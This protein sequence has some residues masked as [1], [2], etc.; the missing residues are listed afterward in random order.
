MKGTPGW[1]SLL[2][3]V[4]RVWGVAVQ[5]PIRACFQGT[6]LYS[7]DASLYST[8]LLDKTWGERDAG[9]REPRAPG[10]GLMPEGPRGPP[11]SLKNHGDQWPAWRDWLTCPLQSRRT[12]VGS[13]S[14]RGGQF[15]YL[16]PTMLWFCKDALVYETNSGLLNFG[17][18]K[19]QGHRGERG[20]SYW[21]RGQAVADKAGVCGRG[22]VKNRAGRRLP[23]SRV[24]R[25]TLWT[26]EAGSGL[27]EAGPLC[28]S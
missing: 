5:G 27:G 21:R 14:R 15:P 12:G 19:L 25:G 9:L 4:P 17:E 13:P 10:K 1:G 16:L 11:S 20:C 6:P 18:Q 2:S 8:R 24:K 22:R 3:C 28:C 7:R 23:S 26:R